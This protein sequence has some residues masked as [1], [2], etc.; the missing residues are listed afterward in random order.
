MKK[1]TGVKINIEMYVCT[2]VS[3][4]CVPAYMFIAYI[5]TIMQRFTWK[6]ICICTDL[7]QDPSLWLGT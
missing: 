1:E 6:V 2:S 3:A 4:T 5:D 7:P